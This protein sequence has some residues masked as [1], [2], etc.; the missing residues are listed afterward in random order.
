MKHTLFV[1]ASIL[2]AATMALTACGPTATPTAAPTTAPATQA[3]TSAPATAA[4]TTAPTAA[5]VNL[6]IWDGYH[7]GGTEETSITNLV[8]QYQQANPNV[9]VTLLE[10]PF[11]DIYTK[12]ETDT[13][14]GGGPDMFTAPNDNLGSEVRAGLIAPIDSYLQGKLTNYTQAGVNGVTVDGKIYA[15]PGIAKAVG[16]FYNTSTIPNPPKTTDDLMALVKSGK[17]LGFVNNGAYYIWGFWSGF[18]GTL[19]DSTGKC[20]AD[21]GGFADALQ[22]LANLQTAGAT[23][24]SDEGKLDTAF[25]QGQLDMIFEGPW[26]LGDFEKNLGSKLGVVPEPTGPKGAFAPMMGIDGWYINPNSTNKQAAIDLALY[27]FGQQGLTTYENTAGDPAART[28]VTSTDPLVKAFADIAAAG[29][30][31]PQSAEFG[32]YWGPFG[33]ALTAVVSGKATPTAAVATACAA[34]NTANKK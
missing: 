23:I 30:P 7:A 29:Y 15:V 27:I 28:D 2:I 6:T 18:G 1:L 26:E 21:Q 9:K 19:L 31:R 17:K 20:V 12:Y 11:S 16:L 3:P 14:A 24:D 5:P 4:P 10:V 32:N 22:Y 33:D 8:N 13:A 34:M 25:E